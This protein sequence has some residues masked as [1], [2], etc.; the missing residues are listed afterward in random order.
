MHQDA[1]WHDGVTEERGM[2]PEIVFGRSVKKV[3]KNNCNKKNTINIIRIRLGRYPS[4]NNSDR[5]KD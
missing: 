1:D 4:H 3:V 5:S 2:D